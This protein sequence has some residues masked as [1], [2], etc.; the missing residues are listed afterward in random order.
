MIAADVEIVAKLALEV[1]GVWAAATKNAEVGHA[2]LLG[3]FV[4]EQATL[5]LD[6]IVVTASIVAADSEVELE[7]EQDDEGFIGI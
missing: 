1:E 6:I 4:V 2:E 5:L 7:N 3:V